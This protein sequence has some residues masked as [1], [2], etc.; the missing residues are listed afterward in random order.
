MG[1]NSRKRTVTNAL[2]ALLFLLF[3]IF[4]SAC[5]NDKG[6]VT[7]PIEEGV[8]SV[9]FLDVGQ[10]DCAFINFTDGKNMLIDTSSASE[11]TA[12]YIIK[13]IEK[14]DSQKL[15]YLLLTHPDEDHIGNAKRIIE[16]FDVGK[17]FVPQVNNLSSFPTFSK[18]I[19]AA[20]EKSIQIVVSDSFICESGEDWFF[21]FLSPKPYQ[22]PESAYND[23]NAVEFPSSQAINDVSPIVYL[24]YAGTRFVFTGDAGTDQEKLV[25]Q[26]YLVGLYKTRYFDREVNLS[27]IDFLKMSHHGSNDA[28]G[29]DFIGLL[30]PDN[31]IVSVG[32]N[33]YN[34]PSTAALNRLVRICPEVKIYRTDVCGT[35]SVVVN[36][37]GKYTIKK[38]IPE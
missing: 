4:S 31:V 37:E 32:E 13:C 33:N 5:G 26:S 36:K 15:D 2:F 30:A 11:T 8:F 3:S 28:S 7:I 10:G 27:K 29:E 17:I 6:K 23:F 38:V 14:S 22:S 24:E 20:K 16:R 18:A 12:E 35:I 19:S 1:K 34:L 25:V 21:A 9:H